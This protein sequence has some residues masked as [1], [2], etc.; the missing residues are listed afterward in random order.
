MNTRSRLRLNRFRP[1]LLQNYLAAAAITICVAMALLA[2]AVSQRLEA[3]IMQAAT[4][5][6]ASLIDTFLGPEIQELA[7][8]PSLQPSTIG[9]LDA[10]LTTKLGARAL[11]VK[12]WLRDGTLAYATDKQLIGQKFPSAHLDAAFSGRV[13]GSFDEL[14][15]PENE[16]DR[17]L[18]I[19][20]IEIYAPFYQSGSRDIIAVGEI[21]NDG[22]RLARELRDIRLATVGIV[23]AVTAP[24][25]LV[26]FLM[27]QRAISTV[28]KQRAALSRRM[29]E[30][31]RLAVQNDLLRREADAARLETIHSNERLLGQIGQDLHDGPIQLLSILMLKFTDQRDAAG[32]DGAVGA[33]ALASGIDIIANAMTD[34]RNLSRG[35]VLPELDEF[36]T[37]ETIRLAVRLHKEM[38]NTDVMC[39]LEALPMWPEPSV[40]ICIFRIVQEGLNNAFHHAGGHGQVVRAAADSSAVTV[41]VE[42][43]GGR[44]DHSPTTI[45]PK[46]G[47]GLTG[48]RRRVAAIGGSLDVVQRPDGMRLIARIP[49][50]QFT[51]RKS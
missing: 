41:V 12:I 51:T 10:M 19:P 36:S 20:L 1:S 11:A 46:S 33:E 14:D 6:G 42:D 18:K 34:L 8:T 45:M 44:T 40:R 37:D 49:A 2:Y 16:L 23:A 21:Y 30:A 31:S 24:M 22:R 32:P 28:T 47:L 7:T 25:L 26:L 27:V 17:K 38:T 15:E 50:S 13:S 35:L 39:E 29:E 9:R 43:Q 5:E 48:L 3:S 4:E